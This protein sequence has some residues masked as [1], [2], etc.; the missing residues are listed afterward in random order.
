[1]DNE[2]SI[3]EFFY[4]DSGTKVNP[5]LSLGGPISNL[6][7]EQV[8]I[9]NPF[10]IGGEQLLSTAG[11]VDYFDDSG[12]DPSFTLDKGKFGKNILERKYGVT[13]TD[14]YG[15]LD[16]LNNFEPNWQSG[17]GY[18]NEQT[19][20]G[21]R[22]SGKMF[23]SDS[24]ITT[25]KMGGL[26]FLVNVTQPALLKNIT[27]DYKL[28]KNKSSFI[29]D[30]VTVQQTFYTCLYAKNTSSLTLYDTDI[31]VARLPN[32]NGLSVELGFSP[33]NTNTTNISNNT[34]SPSG[35]TFSS[36]DIT[37]RVLTG[38]SLDPSDYFAVWVK[39]IVQP[40]FKSGLLPQFTIGV[41]GIS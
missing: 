33:K 9:I 20:G 14:A 40:H 32:I 41:G 37:S 12:N 1:M 17:S 24:G 34:S 10:V 31:H 19:K 27:G 22:E 36:T 38:F 4:S 18:S 29:I 25:S 16:F 6:K 35:I 2:T 30:D 28:Q 11:W 3:I 23:S 7:H 5:E 8:T 13:F 26:S 21:T 15:Y 39:I